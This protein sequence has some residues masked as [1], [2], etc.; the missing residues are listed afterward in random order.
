[1]LET[2]DSKV[3]DS[4]KLIPMLLLYYQGKK[5]YESFSGFYPVKIENGNVMQDS[6]LPVNYGGIPWLRLRAEHLIPVEGSEL[7]I[8]VSFETRN[9]HVGP[10]TRQRGFALLCEKIVEYARSNNANYVTFSDCL[11]EQRPRYDI[12]TSSSDPR[13]K[14]AVGKVVLCKFSAP[15]MSMFLQFSSRD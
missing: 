14:Y 10:K 5:G 1:M 7:E 9:V 3:Q 11:Q 8:M 6:G 4:S 12:A 2:A 15:S 13:L